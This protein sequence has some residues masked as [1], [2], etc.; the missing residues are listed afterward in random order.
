M[1]M[2]P[3]SPLLRAVLLGVLLLFATCIYG[4]D[5]FI[6]ITNPVPAYKGEFGRAVAALGSGGV[7]VGVPHLDS[8]SPM[9][10]RAHL[11]SP[12]GTLLTSFGSPA[13]TPLDLFGRAV[14]GFGSDRVLIGAST[15]NMVYGTGA[16]YLFSTNGL[17]LTTFQ[18][19]FPAQSDIFGSA[20][21]A[22]LPDKVIIGAPQSD[23]GA[24]DSGTAYLFSTNG[25]LLTAFTNP[26][27]AVNDWFGQSVRAVGRD[28]I[29]I[30]AYGDN[31]GG[32]DSGIAYLFSTSGALIS[33]FTNPSAASAELFGN[34][35]VSVGPD[36]VLI[37]AYYARMPGV[38]GMTNGAA[39]LFST[40]GTLLTK[41]TNSPP[42]NLSFFGLALDAFGSD[43]VLI[44]AP[45]QDGAGVVY[46]FATNGTLLTAFTNPLPTY[47]DYFGAAVAAL[48]ED[49]A[50]IGCRYNDAGAV[51]AGSVYLFEARPRLEIDR[52]A[53]ALQVS[54]PSG[55]GR[56]DLQKRTNTSSGAWM[57]APELRVDN[58]SRI[59]ITAQP[60]N[61]TALYRLK[62][63]DLPGGT[64]P[65]TYGERR[66]GANEILPYQKKGD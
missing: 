16:A 57:T 36:K 40:N 2:I 63:M 42:Q 18:N 38:Y 3:Q 51:D 25:T 22:V 15:S 21:A 45:R 41:F 58:G 6:T 8:G 37:G 9:T 39:Y 31:T 26:A 47:F 10:G 7:I 59:Y 61:P 48:G 14:C 56:W 24:K 1:R 53:G 33:T 13:P 20:L 5:T 23:I 46:L 50:I 35:V 60:T 30:T 29:A 54:W 17:L 64:Y 55:W 65:G 43:K 4:Q 52:S 34:A 27:P 11:Y 12:S 28:R 44:G 62:M 66:P 49:R 32:T 19:P